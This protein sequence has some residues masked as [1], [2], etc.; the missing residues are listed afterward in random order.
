MF[1]EIY[2]VTFTFAE[3]YEVSKEC[4]K[5]KIETTNVLA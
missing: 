4:Q 5:L 2:E 1:P 3:I